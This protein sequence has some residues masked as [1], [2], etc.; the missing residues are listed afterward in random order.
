MNK[1]IRK[2]F[3]TE[4]AKY[5]LIITNIILTI[6]VF[7]NVDSLKPAAT[8]N[9]KI[10]YTDEELTNII[11]IQTE[12]TT[13]NKP[14]IASEIPESLPIE[15]E[16]TAVTY[17]SLEVPDINSTFKAYMDYRKIT[18]TASP[19]YKLISLY[20][21]ADEYGFMRTEKDAE[22]DGGQD[23]YMIA[24]GSYYGTEIGTK[25]RITTDTGN[26]FYGILADCKADIHTNNTNQY[27]IVG[28][29][30][31]VEFLVDTTTLMHEVKY[32]GTANRHTPL[33][34]EIIKI[35]K[36]NFKEC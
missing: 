14:V 4:I 5:I 23:Y 22:I 13:I 27:T 31:V 11:E 2:S 35:E 19:Q 33:D 24:L 34:G 26:T 10:A 12:T 20:G 29:P 3:T 15:T 8:T 1:T 16:K 18:N 6:L 25:Y 28:T 30:N 36:I 21:F 7:V 32:H 17:T 9:P